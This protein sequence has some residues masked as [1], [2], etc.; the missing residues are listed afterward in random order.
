MFSLD[1]SRHKVTDISAR[2]HLGQTGDRPFE[3]SLRTENSGSS[4]TLEL[5]GVR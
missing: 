3:A 5:G 4:R 1:E 2:V